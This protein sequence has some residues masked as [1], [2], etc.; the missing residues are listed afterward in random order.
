[1]AMF[2][3]IPATYLIYNLSLLILLMISGCQTPGTSSEFSHPE[4]KH[5]QNS[6]FKTSIIKTKEFELTSLIKNN[7][8]HADI[9]KLVIYIEGDGR[10]WIKK[11]I[12]S[13]NPTPPYALALRLA[14]QDP[15]NNQPD[16]AVAYLARP[17][18]FTQH[19]LTSENCSTKYWS[20]DRFSELVIDNI[21]QAIDILKANLGLGLND[22]LELIGYSGGAAIV[23]LV[24]A[25]R[26]DVEIIRT[27]AGDLNHEMMTA[28]HRTTPLPNCLNPINFTDKLNNIKQIHYIGS[29]DKI[30]PKIVTENFLKRC[31]KNLNSTFSQVTMVQINATHQKGWEEQWTSLVRNSNKN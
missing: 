24:A 16:T 7:N 6:G 14:I 26:N 8:N 21:N 25:R 10:S 31:E 17:C 28:Y 22:K 23:V 18:Q 27:V 15:R 29:T 19:K 11:Q 9:Q 20:S 1:M 3:F 12:L 4:I 5:A 2:K 13:K 30:V